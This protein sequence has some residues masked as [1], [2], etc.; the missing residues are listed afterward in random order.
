MATTNRTRKS[1]P[2]TETASVRRAR[3][4]RPAVV[5]EVELP[6]TRSAE[7]YTVDL[8]EPGTD[9]ERS[10]EKLLAKD[11]NGTHQEFADWFED[12]TGERPDV[13][14][15]Q[16]VLA[17]YQ[18]FQR[19]PEHKALTQA[20]RVAAAEKRAQHE[21]AKVERARKAAAKAGLKVVDA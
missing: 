6:T 12:K 2:T 13:K 21:A 7:G 11:P 19:S 8:V 18:E 4:T 15:V 17:T 16:W 20:K 1:A 9:T 5:A 10:F 3:R 14:T